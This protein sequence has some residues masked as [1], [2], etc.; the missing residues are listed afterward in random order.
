MSQIEQTI[1]NLIPSQFPSFY[2]EQGPNLIAFIQAYYEWMEQSYDTVQLTVT[3]SNAQFA[4]GEVVY[5]SN[6]TAI[7]SSGTIA[8]ISGST[9]NVKNISGTFLANTQ[10]YGETSLAVGTVA[11]AGNTTLLGNPI[12]IARQLMNYSDV[13]TTLE[14][15]LVY[16]TDTYLKGIQ[17]SSLAEKRLT[18][19]KVLDLY[20]AKGNIRGLKL[21]FR[22]VFGE[23]I[24]VY[25]PGEDIFK[26]SDGTWIVPMYLEVNNS[27]RN[28]DFVGKKITGVTS[29]A[30]AFVDRIV[31][32]KIGA[33]LIHLFYITNK[34]PDKDFQTGELLSYDNNL[35][36]VPYVIGSLSNLVV[37]EGGIGF[38][39]GDLVSLTGQFGQEGVGRVA[40]I[41][42]IT[43]EVSFVLNDG[44]WGFANN[45]N[46]LISNTVI[47]LTNVVSTL[48]TNTRPIEKFSNVTIVNPANLSANLYVNAFAY[49]D[50]SSVTL[51][52]VSGTFVNGEIVATYDG[53]QANVISYTA[54]TLVINGVSNS[55]F[56]SAQTVTGLTSGATGTVNTFAT[57]I[58]ITGLNG[59]LT[60]DYKYVKAIYPAYLTIS[61]ENGTLFPGEVIY[62]TNGVSNTAVGTVLYNNATSV[63]Y[64]PISGSFV[65]TA[66][67]FTGVQLD[68]VNAT[69]TSNVGAFSPGEYVY[70]SNGSANIAQGFLLSAT[71]SL[72]VFNTT[73]GTFNTAY[74]VSGQTSGANAVISAFTN[75]ISAANATITNVTP[76]NQVTANIVSISTGTY[77]NLQLGVINTSESIFDYTDMIGGN[78]IWNQMYLLLPL[79]AT[80]YG[81]PKFPSANGSLGYLNDILTFNILQVGEVESII[82]TNPGENYNHAPYVELYQPY[83]GDLRKQDYIINVKNVT[84]SFFPNEEVKQNVLTTN[85]ISVFLGA[86][87][88]FTFGETVYQVNT[89]P[90]G[91]YLANSVSSILLANTGAPN[92]TTTFAAN[93]YILIGGKDLRFVTSVINSIALQLSSAP[94]SQNVAA[95]VSIL[96]ATGYVSNIPQSNLLYVA[97]MINTMNVAN[98]TTFVPSQNVY[99]LTSG[100]TANVT[101]VSLTSYGT[102][103]GKFLSINNNVMSVRRWSVNQDFD[104]SGNNIVGTLSGA[105]ANVVSVATNVI[106][107]YSGDNANIVANVVTGTGT[108]TSLA[109]Q[110]SGIGYVNAETVTFTSADGSK[111]GTAIVNLGK[112]GIGQGY[113]SSTKSF[114]SSD[115]YLQDGSYYQIFSYDIKSSLDPNQYEQMVID[116]VHMSGT[117]LF[118]SVVKSSIVSKQVGTSNANT[119]PI[120]Q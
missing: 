93:N 56:A 101:A 62:Q 54:N 57:E 40:S 112:Q 39:V 63:A 58:G 29:G 96:S 75:N 42:D 116:T 34:S 94:Y 8:S 19:K 44:G 64:V 87:A 107:A 97:S 90:S 30:T 79:N 17:Y 35:T 47:G 2:N 32:R 28:L 110:T 113:Y 5:Q 25:L 111:I 14:E 21:L 50:N 108:V 114:L 1:S 43:G 24:S 84:G 82:R 115:K 119:G 67:S 104:A 61:S 7:I 13:D 66:G 102:A 37:Q 9:I 91:T 48:S 23:D 60:N 86:N 49:S 92:F 31:K 71:S 52:N 81:F 38:A 4:N 73:K 10:I 76:Q 80:Q 16:F 72:L 117:K 109:V 20:R 26:T 106:S 103:L 51:Y 27:P 105:T 89:T 36:D 22:L 53:I 88:N 15:F 69:V 6:S 55:Y 98:T 18:V 99:G 70:Q 77:A 83:V 120:T 41:S 78:N 59:A 12:Y 74:Q 68:T 65:N 45:A 46:I 85:A 100:S 11:V 118:G 33:Q 95:S 3:D